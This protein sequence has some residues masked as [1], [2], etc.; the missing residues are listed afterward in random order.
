M[1]NAA[2]LVIPNE[3]FANGV[4]RRAVSAPSVE[5]VSGSTVPLI[6]KKN[7]EVKKKPRQKARRFPVKLKR[8][9]IWSRLLSTESGLSVAEW[10]SLDKEAASEVIDGIRFL[11]ESRIKK[12]AAK[13]TAEKPTGIGIGIPGAVYNPGL[14]IAGN[15][16]IDP[17]MMVNKV[18]V[19]SEESSIES[20]SD[21]DSESEGDSELSSFSSDSF[22]IAEEDSVS[23]LEFSDV[24]SVYRYPYDLQKMKSGSPLRGSI[25]IN[26]KTIE[27]V[28]DTG[29]SVSIL[30]SKICSDL[31]LVP[32]GDRLHLIGFNQDKDKPTASSVVMDVPVNIGGKI[33]PEHMAV[34]TDGGSDICLLGIPWFQA[35]GISLDLQ[36]SQI[37]VPTCDGMIKIQGRTSQVRRSQDEQEVYLVSASQKFCSSLEDDLIPVGEE[38]DLGFDKSEKKEFNAENISDGV[39]SELKSVVEKYKGCFSEVSGLTSIRGYS[40]KIRLKEDAVP[41]RRRP[42]RLGWSDQELVDSH[43]QEMLDLGIIEPSNGEWSSC[44][45]LVNKKET[46]VK[47]PVVDFR[48]VNKMIVQENFPTPTVSELIETVGDAKIFS[49]FDC[50]SGYH[51]LDLDEDGAEVTGFITNRGAFRYKRLAQGLT[52]GSAQ[53]QRVMSSIFQE[54][55]GEFDPVF[56][57]DILVFSQN[58]EEHKE[59]LEMLFEACVKSNLKLKRKKCFLVKILW[60][61]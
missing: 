33:R 35:Y 60:N 2:N 53:F 57:D 12:S 43:V 16:G 22:C 29:A 21:A 46:S 30:G 28:F 47:R 15:G 13:V 7:V 34:Q 31:G 24:E 23:D 49:T 9:K 54:F 56:L 6:V 20:N 52:N 14:D 17:N 4:K 38:G 8:S 58:M 48:S 36:R 26:G 59:Y 11:K 45:F 3:V 40:A 5:A 27:A 37:K 51:Q 55:I 61:T 50:T 1:V 32:N 10:L 25:S 44:L 42:F 18:M 39:T 41:V 19:D